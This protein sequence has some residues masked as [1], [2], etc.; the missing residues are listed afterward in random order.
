MAN[1]FSLF[2]FVILAIF[3][4]LYHIILIIM[5]AH[6]EISSR[7]RHSTTFPKIFTVKHNR[8]RH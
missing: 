1:I 3:I 6:I 7:G 2:G 4:H 8:T 5:Y